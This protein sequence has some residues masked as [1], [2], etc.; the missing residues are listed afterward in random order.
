MKTNKSE[1]SDLEWYGV[2]VLYK[3][4]VIGEPNA[5]KLDEN[6]EDHQIFEESILL[7]KARSFE[8]AYEIAEKK[9]KESEDSYTNVYGQIVKFQFVESLDAF[10]LCEEDGLQSGTEVYSRFLHIAKEES[11]E[12][13]LSRHYP[14]VIEDETEKIRKSFILRNRDFN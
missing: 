4:L 9:A 6:Y 1:K 7:I 8:Q 5:E 2:K 14:E 11:L 3:N 12:G 10:L 13:V